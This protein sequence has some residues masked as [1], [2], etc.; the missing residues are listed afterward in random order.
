MIPVIFIIMVPFYKVG[1]WMVVVTLF[2]IPLT[3]VVAVT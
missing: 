3:V 1:H 2:F